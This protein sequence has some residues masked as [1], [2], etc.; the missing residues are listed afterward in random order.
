MQMLFCV[1]LVS[2]VS[3]LPFHSVKIKQK[4]SRVIFLALP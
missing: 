1:S 4:L 2:L 3:S